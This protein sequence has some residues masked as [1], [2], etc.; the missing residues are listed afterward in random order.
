MNRAKGGQRSATYLLVLLGESI[1]SIVGSHDGSAWDSDVVVVWHGIPG[2]CEIPSDMEELREVKEFGRGRRCLMARVSQSIRRQWR[3]MEQKSQTDSP[4]RVANTHL[5]SRGPMILEFFWRGNEPTAGQRYLTLRCIAEDTFD[6]R[7]DGLDRT[8]P[9]QHRT[10]GPDQ[11][12]L[13]R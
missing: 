1:G 10:P 4:I 12:G 5:R 3:G 8:G 2:R 9:D 6:V 7:R 11:H 13:A